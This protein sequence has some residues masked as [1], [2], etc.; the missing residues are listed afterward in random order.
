MFYV[1][2]YCA[3]LQVVVGKKLGPIQVARRIIKAD[4]F[5]GLNRGLL[6]CG[7]RDIPSYGL[8]FYL[9]DVIKVRYA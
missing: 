3:W 5:R 7:I 1:Y 2:F 8:Y 6:T 9:Y 4:G